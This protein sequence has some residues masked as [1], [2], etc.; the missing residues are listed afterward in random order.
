MRIPKTDQVI[1]Q[2]ILTQDWGPASRGPSR[3]E[4]RLFS[5]LLQCHSVMLA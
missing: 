1:V 5:T 2:V 3:P 4:Q